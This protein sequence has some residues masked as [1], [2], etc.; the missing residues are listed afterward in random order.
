MLRSPEGKLGLGLGFDCRQ[1]PLFTLWKNPLPAADGYVTGLEPCINLPHTKVFEKS[2]GRVAVL[3]PGET[4]RFDMC[5]ETLGSAQEVARVQGE[6][7]ALQKRARRRSLVNRS[8]VVA[9]VV[10]LVCV[11]AV[12]A[13]RPSDLVLTPRRRSS[14]VRPL[15][16]SGIYGSPRAAVAS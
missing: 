3:A 9:L 2:Q 6:I 14:R 8:G 7:D 15:E 11:P 4:R 10:Q 12:A 5:F 13:A 1:F 16:K